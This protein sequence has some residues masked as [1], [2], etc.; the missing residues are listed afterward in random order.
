LVGKPARKVSSGRPVSRWEKILIWILEKLDWRI[1]H[2]EELGNLY[3]PSCF[4][5]MM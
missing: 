1:L 4:V 5:M 3:R 2:I